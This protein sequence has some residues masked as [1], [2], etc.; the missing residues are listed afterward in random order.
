MKEK[1]TLDEKMFEALKMNKVTTT[2]KKIFKYSGIIGIILL[3]PFLLTIIFPNE[4]RAFMSSVLFVILSLLGFAFIMI[5]V[6][7]YIWELFRKIG[8]FQLEMLTVNDERIIKIRNTSF[9]YSAIITAVLM[10]ILHSLIRFKIVDFPLNFFFPLTVGIFIVF[11]SL[12]YSHYNKRG[13]VD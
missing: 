5:F 3:I 2:E 6:G 12:F 8:N 1:T 4:L 7:G 11:S 9:F 10:A 13:D